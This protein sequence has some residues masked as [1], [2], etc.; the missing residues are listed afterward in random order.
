MGAGGRG[1]PDGGSHLQQG[2]HLKRSLLHLPKDPHS[3]RRA[4]NRRRILCPPDATSLSALSEPPLEGPTCLCQINTSP[5]PLCPTHRCL[6]DEGG[7]LDLVEAV[8][9]TGA[10]ERGGHDAVLCRSLK[11]AVILPNGRTHQ[12]DRALDGPEGVVLL[13][14]FG[15]SARAALVIRLKRKVPQK[16]R[17]RSSV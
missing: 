5:G 12:A 14:H 4:T 6:C 15:R 16:D 10:V 13:L 8:L 11:Q 3:I 9:A 7:V 17:C 2:T 1:G